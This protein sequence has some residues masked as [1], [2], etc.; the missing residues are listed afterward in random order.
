MRKDFNQNFMR[1]ISQFLLVVLIASC[2]GTVEDKNPETTKASP[3]ST[4]P[5]TF[6]GVDRAVPIAEDKV[7]V[8]FFPASGEATDL[9]YMISYDGLANPIT[10]AGGFLE[11]DYRGLLSTTIIGLSPD[12]SYSFEVQVKNNATFEESS[13]KET[14][15][16]ETFANIT[17]DFAGL[18]VAKNVA[19]ADGMTSVRI[20][21]PEAYHGNPLLPPTE[22]DVVEYEVIL[23]N[24]DSGS[25]ADFDSTILSEPNKKVFP[26][27]TNVVSYVANGLQPDTE[28][29][30]RVRAIHY[31][32]TQNSADVNYLKEQNN[33]YRV[34]R[35]LSADLAD[36]DFDPGERS[37][38]RSAGAAGQSALEISWGEVTG[39]FDHYR[40]YYTATGNLNNTGT[41][42]E[43]DCDPLAP[44]GVVF[45][46]KKVDFTNN[47]TTIADLIPQ[48]TYSAR[49]FICQTTTCENGKRTPFNDISADTTPPVA[50]F[51]GITGD[52][53]ARDSNGLDQAFLLMDPPE[54]A[55]GVIEGI[56]VK[57]FQNVALGIVSDA[58]LN[59][60]DINN[61]GSIDEIN[62]VVPGGLGG[63]LGEPIGGLGVLNFDYKTATEVAITGIDPFA[64]N[65]YT[66]MLVPYIYTGGKI[67]LIEDNVTPYDF[68]PSIIT[69]SAIDFPGVFSVTCDIASQSARVRWNT[70]IEGVYSNF[71][72]FWTNGGSFDYGAGKAE[73]AGYDQILMPKSATEYSIP[74][75]APG[76]YRVGV[77]SYLSAGTGAYSENNGG[78]GVITI[79][80]DCN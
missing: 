63:A 71:K 3:A 29:Y 7:E 52:E 59:L 49:I 61:D 20:E 27:P 32:A 18:A 10:L 22:K 28:Y 50:I 41:Y 24:A 30:V 66:F 37:L 76:T 35:T 53:A 15:T 64:I 67:D 26:V 40:I 79:P 42:I 2:V 72:V 62:D 43:D 21:W 36:L 75:L 70:P 77:L 78:I 5:L 8:Y 14:R 25:P 55:T 51:G 68:T 19:G 58:Y 60:P 16:A 33:K 54:L 13:S 45:R 74:F 34:V 9:T 69:P 39:A 11:L 47:A 1:L 73:A 31:G 17:S 46:C 38:A 12:T 57:V 6:I 80:G 56:A 44:Y 48:T 4:L 23:I 65:T